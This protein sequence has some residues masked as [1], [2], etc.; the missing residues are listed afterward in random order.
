M[1]VAWGQQHVHISRL[2]MWETLEVLA[3]IWIAC[4]MTTRRT[5]PWITTRWKRTTTRWGEDHN[6]IEYLNLRDK[7]YNIQDKYNTRTSSIT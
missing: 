2:I 3:A 7:L 5:R 1:S 4:R 6:M